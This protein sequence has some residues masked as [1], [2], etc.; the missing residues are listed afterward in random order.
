MH[1]AIAGT[2]LGKK[3]NMH[4]N[5]YYKNKAVFEQSIKNKYPNTILH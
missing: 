4:Q 1:I 2:L 5:N 3:T